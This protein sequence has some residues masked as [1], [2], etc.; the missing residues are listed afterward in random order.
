LLPQKKLRYPT[1]FRE[2]LVFEVARLNYNATRAGA[3]AREWTRA[4]SAACPISFQI[5]FCS[6]RMGMGAFSG[7][8]GT[9][10]GFNDVF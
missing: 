7:L 2:C 6:K 1:S 5:Q 4:L 10:Y 8:P 3:A 9:F